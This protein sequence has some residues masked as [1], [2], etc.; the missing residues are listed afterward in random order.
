MPFA[1]AL[2]IEPLDKLGQRNLEALGQNFHRRQT[3]LFFAALH[4]GDV[5]SVDAQLLGSPNLSP[6]AILSQLPQARSKADS[7]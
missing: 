3:D 5:T 2:T 1:R 7:S 6:A 4:V